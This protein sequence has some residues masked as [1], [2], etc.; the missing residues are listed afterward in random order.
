MYSTHN[1]S[2][3]YR[4]RPIQGWFNKHR[5]INVHGPI[6]NC[7]ICQSQQDARLCKHLIEVSRQCSRQGSYIPSFIKIGQFI[8]YSF[9]LET[10]FVTDRCDGMEHFVRML[11]QLHFV[12]QRYKKNFIKT[13]KSSI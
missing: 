5:V 3:L 8:N 2:V 4:T 10:D 11:S 1:C 13:K 9:G 12:K 6:T 7:Q